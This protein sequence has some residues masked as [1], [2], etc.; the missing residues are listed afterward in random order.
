KEWRERRPSAHYRQDAKSVA[1]Q[2]GKVGGE[3]FALGELRGVLLRYRATCEAAGIGAMFNRVKGSV[4]GFLRDTVT[5]KH[6]L[7][8]ECAAV[9]R[10]PERRKRRG[11]PQSP[12]QARVIRE[13][14]GGEAGRAW[15]AMCCT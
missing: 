7:Y 5:S 1:A 13:A 8:G 10:L 15:W 11:N 14:L 6:T 12:A 9:R 4:L 3:R 2:L